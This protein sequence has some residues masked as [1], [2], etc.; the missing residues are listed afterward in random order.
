MKKSNRNKSTS[1][2]VPPAAVTA[3]PHPA[4]IDLDL[5]S[6]Y[7]HEQVHIYDKL[8]SSIS[9]ICE[10]AYC[11]SEGIHICVPQTRPRSSSSASSSSS[12]RTMPSSM[13]VARIAYPFESP[14]PTHSIAS[15]CSSNLFFDKLKEKHL[16]NLYKVYKHRP[17]SLSSFDRLLCSDTTQ[18][19]GFRACLF[20]P[21]DI[22][23][24]QGQSLLATISCANEVFLYEIVSSSQRFF[25][26]QSS[27][28]K[29]DLTKSLQENNQLE[30]Y[31]QDSSSEDDYRLLY[32]HLTSSILWSRTG[33]LFFQLQY[34]GHLIIW[35]FDQSTIVNERSL[36]TIDTKISRPLSMTWNEECQILLIIGKE[37][38]RVLLHVDSMKLF[39]V[40]V[41]DNDF[42]NTEHAQLIKWNDKTLVLVESKMNYCL[43]HT[44][45]LTS[46][47]VIA[48]NSHRIDRTKCRRLG[49][50]VRE[51]PGRLSSS[52][53]AHCRFTAA[54]LNTN[55]SYFHCYWL[56]RW[57]DAFSVHF[58]SSSSGHR[59]CQTGRQ[60][61]HEI[62]LSE[63]TCS[64]PLQFL[65]QRTTPRS[66]LL[67][68]DCCTQCQI[69][70]RFLRIAPLAIGEYCVSGQHH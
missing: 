3:T 69:R 65:S 18:Y 50:D 63:T 58:P 41:N 44:M 23:L 1:S 9:S 54:A 30:T 11:T 43:M 33:K 66:N 70:L 20:S 40:K 53:F 13:F 2:I 60:W 12:S 45:T 29:L 39:P 51:Q 67:F 19:K 26:S 47:K 10:I 59:R 35:K 56:R 14:D 64:S 34:S 16:P 48:R 57:H 28:L 5:F 38:Q 49:F 68:A 55:Q 25:L 27:N 42:M 21:C 32:I 7:S 22:T 24:N 46:N 6:S 8:C 15:N 62:V 37:N 4:T 31:L 52:S 17:T 36:T 61:P